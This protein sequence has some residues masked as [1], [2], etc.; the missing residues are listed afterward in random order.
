MPE[1]LGLCRSAGMR[2]IMITGDHPATAFAIAQRLGI[3]D[4][5]SRVC[6]GSELDSLDD[7]GL[8][9]AVGRYTAYSRVSPEHKTRISYS[10]APCGLHYRHD[11]GRVNDAPSLRA[12]DIGVGMG[13][14]G[15]DVVRGVADIIL[16]DDNFPT[17]VDATREGRRIYDNIC[18]AVQFLLSS[19][20]QRD[21]YD[22]HRDRARLYRAQSRSD[23]L[24]KS[25]HRYI[26]GTRARTRGGRAGCHVTPAAQP[27]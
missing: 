23:T 7:D 24:D 4:S 26:S 25:H 18:K 11:R 27:R 16:S 22:L 12:A 6:L 2:V 20:T 21:N 13:R 15:S 19:K 3:A 8:S 14:G 5:P 17:L 1:A 10:T 9:R